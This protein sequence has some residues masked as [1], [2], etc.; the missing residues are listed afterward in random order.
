MITPTIYSAAIHAAAA[1]FTD[2]PITEQVLA[3]VSRM[4]EARASVSPAFYAAY[5][6]SIRDRAVLG[7]KEATRIWAEYEAN[8]AGGGTR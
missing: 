7:F 1:R 2:G 4:E 8:Y 3:D 6:Q 5:A